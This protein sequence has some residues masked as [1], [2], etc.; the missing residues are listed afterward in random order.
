MT[1]I[2]VVTTSAVAGGAE[3]ALLGLIRRL[4]DDIEPT[5]ALLQDGDLAGWLLEQECP[6]VVLEAGRTR[7]LHRTV[8]VVA[9]LRG[10][11]KRLGAGVVLSSQSKSHVYGGLAAEL[12]GTPAVWWQHGIPH[13]SRIESVAGL[14]PSTAIVC[15]SSAAED[16][17]RRLTP[18][19]RVVR[20]APGIDVDA[21]ARRRGDGRRVRT[22]LGWADERIVG[23][24][25]RL[26][27]SK[28]QETFIRAAARVGHGRPD[29][30]FLVVGGAILG[31]EGS[32]PDDLRA[33]AQQLGLADRIHFAGH[34]EDVA[35][36]FDACDVVVHA[37]YD[38]P[39]GLVLLEAM[40]LEKPIVASDS[41]GPRDI[42]EREVSGLLVPPADPGILAAAIERLLSDA[43]LATRLR[44]GAALRARSF[45]EQRMA[46][47]FADL[48]RGIAAQSSV[49]ASRRRT[50]TGQSN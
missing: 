42:V 50:I 34:Q 26:E 41:G 49:V 35:P 40:A 36:W 9:K 33:L 15:G 12:V 13:R 20:I 23:I 39:F 25:G 46:D 28:G 8:Q 45:G 21:L 14:V 16:A 44:A 30:R 48:L 27:Q 3:R 18:R 17:Q 2:V 10:L 5:V 24:I 7:H 37:A 22:A 31:W 11:A 4:P 1:R 38:E 6:V 32:Y 29:V 43:A 19:R 47:E